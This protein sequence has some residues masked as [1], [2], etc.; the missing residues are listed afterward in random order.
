MKPYVISINGQD[1]EHEF[2]DDWQAWSFVLSQDD[3]SP[4]KVRVLQL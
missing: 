2:A 3:G 1:E 4:M